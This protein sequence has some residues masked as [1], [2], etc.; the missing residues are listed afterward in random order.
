MATKLY[1]AKWVADTIQRLADE[2]AANRMPGE[3]RALIGLRTRGAI[4]A[5]RL[6][7]ALADK[8]RGLAVGYLDATLYRADLRGAD[9]RDA[10][11]CDADL[12]GALGLLAS[13]LDASADP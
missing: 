6:A 13:M 10:E 1:D 7:A 8:G 2:I 5:D 11:L 9:L 12:T 4:L 3:E